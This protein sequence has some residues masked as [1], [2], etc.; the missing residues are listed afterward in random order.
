MSTRLCLI[1]CGAHAMQ[2]YAPAL[3]RLSKEDDHLTL[4]ACCDVDEARARAMAQ[5][6]GFAG[7]TTDFEAML[8]AERPDAVIAVVPYYLA[9]RIAVPVLRAGYP[10]LLEKPPGD[11]ANACRRIAKAAREGGAVHQIAFNRHYMP[12]V[13]M[14]HRRLRETEGQN[15][16]QNIDYSMYRQNRTEDY[17]F[18][19]AIHGVDVVGFLAGSRYKDIRFSY[20]MLPA[21]GP[22]CYNIFM[23]C[24]FHSGATAQLRF[25]VQ[26]GLVTERLLATSAGETW[27]SHFPIWH[28][29][30]SPG[31][32]SLYQGDRRVEHYTGDEISD[33]PALFETNGFYAEASAFLRA[34][35]T[36]TQPLESADAALQAMEIAEYIRYRL[37]EYHD[38]AM[39]PPGP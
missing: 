12:M 38:G 31:F 9:E 36:G 10:L 32:L 3:A 39:G 27:C 19:T 26:S 5:A 1:G 4:A 30:D 23:D 28:G 35:R 34:V 8:Q 17:F 29:A 33:G 21:L 11:S 15:P 25:L 14:L 2:V 7:T 16:I 37:P 20:Q 24:G 13:R 6:A 18:V 22:G